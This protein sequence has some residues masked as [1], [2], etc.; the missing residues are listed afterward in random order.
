MAGK[1]RT[2][3]AQVEA[4]NEIYKVAQEQAN[5]KF[6]ALQA[7]VDDIREEAQA[8]GALHAI[9]ANI[10]YN[11]LMRAVTLQRVKQGKEYKKGG[12]TWDE[13]CESL[14]L[15]RRT[16]DLMLE[17]IRPVIE[18]FSAKFAGFCGMPFS[19]IRLLGKSI[20]AN[21]AEIKDGTI[22]YG[23]ESIPLTPENAD[24]IQAL[25][26]KIDQDAKAAKEEAEATIRAKD[27]VLKSK[28]QLLTKQEKELAR[29]EKTARAKNLL[30]EED[31]VLGKIDE[32]NVS[33]NGYCL[34]VE[35]VYDA[36]QDNPFNAGVAAFITLCDNIKMRINAFRE[37]AVANL[38]PA[39]M[40]PDEEWVP[41]PLRKDGE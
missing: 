14:G 41:P 11:E 30:P 27:K 4:A 3:D 16:V 19:K 34:S 6:D 39:G 31:A 12:M 37:T 1:A 10:A 32:L 26:E 2:T 22:V 15:A 21:L 9:D 38:A 29:L 5:Q 40:V 24:E 20:S 33:L 23:D 36:L 18:A 35:N 7:Q 13:F 25:I 8:M 28:E 17:D